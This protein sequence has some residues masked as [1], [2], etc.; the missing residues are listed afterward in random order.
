MNTKTFLLVGNVLLPVGVLFI[1]LIIFF[2]PA[3]GKSITIERRQAMA[4]CVENIM[5]SQPEASMLRVS[6]GDPLMMSGKELSAKKDS[7]FKAFLAKSSNQACSVAVPL[8]GKDSVKVDATVSKSKKAK[9]KRVKAIGIQLRIPKRSAR[10]E[11]EIR[12]AIERG[13]KRLP[14][15]IQHFG[16]IVEDTCPKK[17]IDPDL[18]FAK[19]AVESQGYINAV[20]DSG[21]VS[22]EQLMLKTGQHLLALRGIIVTNQDSLKAMLRDP[23]LNISLG[24]D[25][26]LISMQLF[27]SPVKALVGYEAGDDHVLCQI[28]RY[29]GDVEVPY[30]R[31]VYGIYAY[32]K[33]HPELRDNRGEP[34]DPAMRAPSS[35]TEMVATGPQ[36]AP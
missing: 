31:K 14:F 18:E 1:V 26:F 34:F 12:V 28:R 6:K 3:I 8:A 13:I 19:I 17:G 23:R 35:T 29:G 11:S 20:S 30:Y 24:T 4:S 22:L 21:A 10:T 25:H 7:L 33:E 15:I 5:Q 2:G 16:E 27:G 9:V 36:P 32:L